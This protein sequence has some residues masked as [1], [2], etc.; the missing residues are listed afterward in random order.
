M[1]IYWFKSCWIGHEFGRSYWGTPMVVSTEE[2]WLPF[3]IN[4]QRYVFTVRRL[5]TKEEIIKWGSGCQGRRMMTGQKNVEQN[6]KRHKSGTWKGGW[7]GGRY[8]GRGVMLGP[9]KG[10]YITKDTGG[11]LPSAKRRVNYIPLGIKCKKNNN[12][13]NS[14][15]L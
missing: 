13:I 11:V 3:G 4:S 1:I 7:G 8:L 10:H 5:W 15:L 2:H 14:Y 12:Y 9:N 6:K